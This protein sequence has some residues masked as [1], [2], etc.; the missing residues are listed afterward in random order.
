MEP[1]PIKGLPPPLHWNVSSKG[2][3]LPVTKSHGRF[4]A[5]Q[6]CVCR[7][8]SRSSFGCA[9]PLTWFPSHFPA[10]TFQSLYS[11][12]QPLNVTTLKFTGKATVCSKEGWRAW[13]ASVPALPCPPT[14]C[15]SPRLSSTAAKPFLQQ[16]CWCDLRMK[17][18]EPWW[19]R[20]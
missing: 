19:H 3:D 14:V 13:E 8:R 20:W 18:R 10:V 4:S 11:P 16:L 2:G 1:T 9:V 7:V 15:S 12:L 17:E 6:V 5:G